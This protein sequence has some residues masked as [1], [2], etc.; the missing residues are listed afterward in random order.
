MLKDFKMS[1]DFAVFAC[2]HDQTKTLTRNEQFG[3]DVVKFYNPATSES[4]IQ[5]YFYSDSQLYGAN[6]FYDKPVI[7]D[8]NKGNDA[9]A[10]LA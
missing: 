10:M 2:K 8:A 1:F 5:V 6:K 7:N 9:A 4:E 3:R